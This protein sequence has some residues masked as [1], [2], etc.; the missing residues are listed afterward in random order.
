MKRVLLTG[1]AGFVGAGLARRLLHAGHE[2][3]LLLR[4]GANLW[5]LDAVRAALRLHTADL[6]DAP[7]VARGVAAARPEWVFHLAAQGAYS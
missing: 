3:N 4:P 6:T 5:R 1:G 2:L 7:A